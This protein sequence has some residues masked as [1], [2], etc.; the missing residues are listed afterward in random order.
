MGTFFDLFDNQLIWF[1]G[2]LAEA[3]TSVSWYYSPNS[4]HCSLPGAL[5]PLKGLKRMF[6]AISSTLD[7]LTAF[8]ETETRE[9]MR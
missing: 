5:H 6:T 1:M 4:Y 9:T 2:S 3:C 8:G 7:G